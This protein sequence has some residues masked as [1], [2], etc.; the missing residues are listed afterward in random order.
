[1]FSQVIN[2]L[3]EYRK[4]SIEA[5]GLLSELSSLVGFL[6]ILVFWGFKDCE[7]G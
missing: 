4:I 2:I 3:W 5:V 7:W 6:L 1:M